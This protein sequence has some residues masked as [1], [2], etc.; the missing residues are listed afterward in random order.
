MTTH[1]KRRFFR[2][3][4][5]TLFI[6]VTVFCVWMGITAKLAREQ[7][8][9][10][11]TIEAL[12]GRV[13]YQHETNPSDPPGPEWLRRLIGDEY[14]FSIDVIHFSNPIV[15]DTSLASIKSLTGVKWLSLTGSQITDTGLVHLKGPND[16]RGLHLNDTQITD[17]GLEQLKELTNLQRLYLRNTQVTDEGVKK[18]QQELPS[19][20]ITR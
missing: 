3:S 17:T 14:F 9:A 2:Y 10:V 11:E 16:L 1:S 20:Q 18:L 19:L 13:Q 12:G 5:R 15:N 7:K 4:L 8:Q 6:V